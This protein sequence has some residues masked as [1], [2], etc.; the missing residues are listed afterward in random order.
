M[1]EVLLRF[2]TGGNYLLDIFLFKQ[3]VSKLKTLGGAEILFP[4]KVA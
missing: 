4:R 2:I 3:T 1:G